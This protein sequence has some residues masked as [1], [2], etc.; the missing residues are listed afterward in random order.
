MSNYF[1]FVGERDG[2]QVKGRAPE[3]EKFGLEWFRIRMRDEG[4]DPEGN[5][6]CG[7][8]FSDPIKFNNMMDVY[9]DFSIHARSK[10][11]TS[12]DK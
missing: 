5:Q 12:L 10:E 6:V 7:L 11:E 8:S 1:Y 9:D 2:I 3:P 4:F